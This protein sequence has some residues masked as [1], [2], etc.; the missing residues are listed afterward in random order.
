M[1]NSL[2]M[3]LDPGAVGSLS[4]VDK[5]HLQHRSQNTAQQADLAAGFRLRFHL[6]RLRLRHGDKI[7]PQWHKRLLQLPGRQLHQLFERIYPQPQQQRFLRQQRQL[8]TAL[9]QER[10]LEI[11][12]ARGQQPF[13]PFCP[14]F[15]RLLAQL[16]QQP[17]IVT[18]NA[19]LNV[20]RS[21]IPV[22]IQKFIVCLDPGLLC[23]GRQ[24]PGDHGRDPGC[25]KPAQHADPFVA[26]LH[27]KIPQVFHAGDGIPNPLIGKMGRAQGNPFG[28]K[29]RIPVQQGQKRRG[30]RGGA[31]RCAGA[32]DPLRRDLH[33]A[34]MLRLMH[35]RLIQHLFQ[36]QW[37]YPLAGRLAFFLFF[38]P[39]LQGFLIFFK[40]SLQLHNSHSLLIKMCKKAIPDEFLLYHSML[41]SNCNPFLHL[42]SRREK[43]VQK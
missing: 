25:A 3:T 43:N 4:R 33:I 37:P 9:G 12:E 29:F 34:H 21:R 42:Y 23:H 1:A 41:F 15:S 38:L 6:H 11:T 5:G 20:I 36:H 31:S 40:R 26:L 19:V 17:L 14:F 35:F 7:I 30:K 27:I 2:L 16:G 24:D 22:K 32:Y 39:R 8:F 13:F 18:R 28:G 10:F